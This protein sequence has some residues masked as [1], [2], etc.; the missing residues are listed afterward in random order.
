[1][2]HGP[3]VSN[4]I[5]LLIPF[6]HPK[7][8]EKFGRLKIFQQDSSLSPFPCFYAVIF[9]PFYKWAASWQNQQKGHLPSLIRVFTVRMKKHWI[10]SYPL[11]AQWS[12][13]TDWAD[14]QADLS[15][16]WVHSHFVGFV[17]WQLKWAISWKKVVYVIGEQQR[18]RSACTSLQSHQ[19]LCCSLPTPYTTSFRRRF[20]RASPPYE[21]PS[22]KYYLTMI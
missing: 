12:L 15:L 9:N 13:W 18:R 17:M 21:T 1:M 14:A 3:L 22:Y 19:C 20:F 11:S 8:E 2:A 5:C 16:C 10:L 7:N 4:F 6:K